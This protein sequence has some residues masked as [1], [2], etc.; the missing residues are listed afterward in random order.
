MFR[1]ENGSIICRELLGLGRGPSDPTPEARTAEYYKRRPCEEYVAI[2][3][4]IT[5]EIINKYNI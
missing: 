2:A 4:K 1:C 5:E 3:A